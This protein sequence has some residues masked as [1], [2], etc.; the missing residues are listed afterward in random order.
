VTNVDGSSYLSAISCPTVSLCVAT[1]ASGDVVTSTDPTGGAAAWKVTNVDGSSYLSAISC[2][3]TSLC[4]AVDEWGKAV[5]G[6]RRRAHRDGG[7]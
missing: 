7:E 5:T 6:G 4:V 3:T 1:D 2:P